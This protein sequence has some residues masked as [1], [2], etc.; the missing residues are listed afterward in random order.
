MKDPTWESSS[1]ADRTRNGI[2]R[3]S[4]SYSLQKDM[5]VAR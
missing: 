1:P 3:P 5:V 4:F 2:S